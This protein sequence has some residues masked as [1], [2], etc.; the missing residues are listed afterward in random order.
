MSLLILLI[1]CTT[2]GYT[3][4]MVSAMSAPHIKGN[5]PVLNQNWAAF[6]YFVAFIML[7]AFILLNLYIGED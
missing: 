4:Y 3:P 6:F 5:V 7:V 2:N 1:A